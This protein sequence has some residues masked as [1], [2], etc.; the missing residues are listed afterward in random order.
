MKTTLLFALFCL[1]TSAV[2]SQGVTLNPHYDDA[3][4]KLRVFTVHR[5]L[6][7]FCDVSPATTSIKLIWTRDGKD[8]HQESDLEGRFQILDAEHKFIID[9]TR[10]DD[11]GL[12][13]C[14]LGNQR[15]IFNVVSNVASRLPKDTQLTEGESLWIVCRVV[16]TAPKITWIL[17]DNTSLTNSTDHI[18]LERENDVANSALYIAS[19]RLEDR[20][21]YKCIAENSA[22]SIDGFEPSIATGIVRVRSKLAP[23]W[24]LCGILAQCFVLFVIL[25][26]YEK[27]FHDKDD[28]EDERDDYIVSKKSNNKD[29]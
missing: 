28:L 11:D 10:D 3:N 7:L 24:P 27:F 25:Y 2:Y 23:L 26:I 13:A 12:Y 8:V 21:N 1:L 20:G 9:R 6:I 14:E 22:T 18:Q 17:P 29:C 19:T 5:P 4:T 16:G 15:A